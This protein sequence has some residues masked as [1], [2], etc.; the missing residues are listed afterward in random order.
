MTLLGAARAAIVV[1]VA[2][3]TIACGRAEQG[4]PADALRAV[5]ADARRALDEI[6]ELRGELTTLRARLVEARR[7]RSK[8]KSTLDANTERLSASLERVR[9]SLDEVRSASASGRDEAQAAQDRAASAL[10]AAN[11]AARDLAV[12]T[13]RFDYHLRRYH[14]GA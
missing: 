1:V 14:G 5:R 6:A 12:L 4:A 9:R 2:L 10:A 3:A 13:R 7:G 8:L 11:A